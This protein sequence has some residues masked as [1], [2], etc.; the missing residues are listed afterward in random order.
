MWQHRNRSLSWVFVSRMIGIICF[1]IVVVLAKILENFTTPG[2]IYQQAAE[3]LLFANFWLLLLIGII[4]LVA[5]LFI[6]IPFP[7]N[8]PGPVSRQSGV[9]SVSRWSSA[10]SSG[11]TV[12][13]GQTFTRSSGCSRS[14]SYR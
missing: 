3:G 9:S 12:R 14:C 11:S 7:L 4:F 13:P 2:G 6:A 5:D 8:L 1:L 10:Y